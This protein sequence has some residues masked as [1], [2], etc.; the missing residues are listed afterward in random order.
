MKIKLYV[1]LQR[2]RQTF[3]RAATMPLRDVQI[4][5]LTLY[6]SAAVQPLL[7]TQDPGTHDTVDNDTSTWVPTI[8]PG[9]PGKVLGSWLW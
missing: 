1:K 9:D 5:Y 4:L 6:W 8:H 7:A 3:S 2:K